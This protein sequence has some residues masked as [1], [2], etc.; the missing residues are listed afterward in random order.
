MD[1]FFPRGRGWGDKLSIRRMVNRSMRGWRNKLSI[2]GKGLWD[3][4]CVMG[5]GLSDKWRMSR[6]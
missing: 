3:K 6:R 1:K 5:R 2:I 4:L